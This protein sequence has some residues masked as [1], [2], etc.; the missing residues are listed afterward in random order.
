MEM[1]HTTLMAL[2]VT[3]GVITGLLIFLLIYRSALS[4]HEERPDFP[5]F[6][7]GI[8]GE[9]TAGARCQNREVSK[10]ITALL[11]VF[12]YVAR[13]QRPACGFGRG[14]AISSGQENFSRGSVPGR[15]RFFCV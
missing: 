13:C 3:W 1:L 12:R 2:L 9:R 14:S 5:R 8:D 15:R 6:R 7:R 4:T 10:P 11:I